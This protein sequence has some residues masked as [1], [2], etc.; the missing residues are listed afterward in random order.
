MSSPSRGILT[1]A[2]AAVEAL[3]AAGVEVAFGLPGVHNLPLWRELSSSPVRLRSPPTVNV[4]LPSM[5]MPSCSC[6]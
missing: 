6:A 5:H 4:M 3:E 1:G 2:R